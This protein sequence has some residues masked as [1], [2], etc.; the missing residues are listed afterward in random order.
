MKLAELK[1]ELAQNPDL[2]VRFT[3]GNAESIPAHAH[4]TEVA[5][6]D[7]QFVDCG[8][9]FRT[10]SLCR[11]QTWVSDDFDHRL[12]AGVL[13]KILEKS[14]SFLKTDDIEVDVE[15]ELDY[16]TQF[17]ISAVK[18]N[19]SEMII[20]LTERHTDCLA[21]EKCCAPAPKYDFNPMKLQF[22]QTANS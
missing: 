20:Q 19:G 9:T 12:K 7:K 11:L 8:G 5:R 2:P 21:K 22:K 1:P 10:H 15:H 17:P 3:F 18:P 13:L 4:V 16:I 6:I 14:A